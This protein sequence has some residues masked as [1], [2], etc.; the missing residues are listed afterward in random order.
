MI[1]AGGVRCQRLEYTRSRKG[2]WRVCGPPATGSGCGHLVVRRTGPWVRRGGHD[3]VHGDPGGPVRQ[4]RGV[5]RA[6]VPVAREKD[7]DT[8]PAAGQRA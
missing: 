6:L 1:S 5:V 8:R 7:A 3:A 2:A 4:K